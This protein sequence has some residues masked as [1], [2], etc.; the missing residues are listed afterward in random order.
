MDFK[1]TAFNFCWNFF[2]D[3]EF[4][5][6][7]NGKRS[8]VRGVLVLTDDEVERLI[9]VDIPYLAPGT[10]AGEEAGGAIG[11]ARDQK[12]QF[13]RQETQE[14]EAALPQERSL[15]SRKQTTETIIFFATMVIVKCQNT[16]IQS[17]I[18]RSAPS[19]LKNGS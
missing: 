5:S 15:P 13:L 8:T 1:I 7:K 11:G 6:L 14:E 19:R 10:G 12:Q 9:L 4:V 17:Q 3:F 18:I 16:E 2:S